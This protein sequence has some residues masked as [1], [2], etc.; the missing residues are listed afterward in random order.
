MK[1]RY[2][3]LWAT[4]LGSALAPAAHADSL[5][6]PPSAPGPFGRIDIHDSPAPQLVKRQPIWA[7]RPSGAFMKQPVYFHVPPG[8][9]QNWRI[10]CERYQACGEAVLFVLDS[11]Y[12][13]SYLPHF[14]QINGHKN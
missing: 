12:Q 3:L 1:S 4:L 11:W 6:Q 7:E 14:R 9:Q 8:H 10:F 2:S 13:D 5:G